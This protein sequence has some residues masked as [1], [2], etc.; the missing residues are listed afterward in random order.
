MTR[1]SSSLFL[2]NTTSK[3]SSSQMTHYASQLIVKEWIKPYFETGAWFEYDLSCVNRDKT[4]DQVLHDAVAKGAEI[5][6]IFKGE[7]RDWME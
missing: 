7:N 6:A 5:G 4:G 1:S 2:T 3:R